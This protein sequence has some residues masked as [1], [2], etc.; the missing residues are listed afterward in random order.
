MEWQICN[1]TI[2]TVMNSCGFE[3]NVSL[4]LLVFTYKKATTVSDT[5]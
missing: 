2:I 4:S 1:I 3:D 5:W